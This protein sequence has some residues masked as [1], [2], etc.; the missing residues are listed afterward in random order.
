MYVQSNSE[1]W[2]VSPE[3]VIPS[4]S[5]TYQLWTS[6]VAARGASD[7]SRSEVECKRGLSLLLGSEHE[8]PVWIG[9]P[10]TRC[11]ERYQRG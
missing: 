6:M 9:C 1:R 8:G 3:K 11:G 7:A 4:K 10:Q 5:R 2:R